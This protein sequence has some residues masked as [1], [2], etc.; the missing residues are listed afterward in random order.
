MTYEVRPRPTAVEVGASLLGLV[1]VLGVGRVAYGVIVNLSQDGWDTGARAVFLGLNTIVL[2]FAL[3]ALVLAHQV[4]QGRLWAWIVSLIMLPFTAL[5]GGL[6]LLITA[7]GGAFPFAGSAV[8]A[9]SL[10]A[11]LALTV[12]RSARAYFLAKPPPPV[13][14]HH[15]P[16]PGQPWGP[17]RS[18]V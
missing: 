18:R 15:G 16:V 4:R 2:I 10:A 11:L 17:D 12:P 8:V 5:V 3:F 7:V 1:G 9:A 6:L 14:P 13:P